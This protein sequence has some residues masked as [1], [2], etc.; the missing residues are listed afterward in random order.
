MVLHRQSIG[1]AFG[2]L[3]LLYAA[4]LASPA[5][6]E[7]LRLAQAQCKPGDVLCL[8]AHSKGSSQSGQGTGVKTLKDK[9]KP[10]GA[11]KSD[12]PVGGNAGTSGRNN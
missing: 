9:D 8:G 1:I 4:G 10:E 2:M 12:K 6:A 11:E 7:G 5:S 3:T